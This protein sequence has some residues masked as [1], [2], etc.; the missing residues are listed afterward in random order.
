MQ[1]GADR[2]EAALEFVAHRDLQRCRRHQVVAQRVGA[3]LQRTGETI[4]QTSTV[5]GLSRRHEVADQG[6]YHVTRHE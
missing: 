6:R 5:G 2:I 3:G 1:S 4:V